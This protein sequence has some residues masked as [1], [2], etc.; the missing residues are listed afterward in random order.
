MW[1]RHSPT[2]SAIPSVAHSLS[3][4][5]AALVSG[6]PGPSHLG[7]GAGGT[8][9]ALI[10]GRL[11][12]VVPVLGVQGSTGSTGSTG[13]LSTGVCLPLRGRAAMDPGEQGLRGGVPLCEGP[14]GCVSGATHPATHQHLLSAMLCQT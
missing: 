12:G 5:K 11:P 2:P 7:Q 6:G 1:L 13:S 8:G 14:G 3:A 4:T 10:C 9:A